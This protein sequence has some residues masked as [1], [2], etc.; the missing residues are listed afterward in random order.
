MSSVLLL[1]LAVVSV[2]VALLVSR[3]LRVL[4]W[5]SLRN[6]PPASPVVDR[7]APSLVAVGLGAVPWLVVL[8]ITHHLLSPSHVT[9]AFLGIAAWLSLMAVFGVMV[10]WLRR[11]IHSHPSGDE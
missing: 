7:Y 10:L 9:S 2:L 1:N 5:R 8:N 6:R 11:S 3:P 4:V